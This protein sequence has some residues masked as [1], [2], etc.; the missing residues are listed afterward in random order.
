M[1]AQD[2]RSLQEAYMEVVENQQLDEGY[3][4]LPKKKMVRKINNTATNAS[5]ARK[6][7][8]PKT[9]ASVEKKYYEPIKK[10]RDVK[11]THSSEKA[12]AKAAANKERGEN[13]KRAFGNRLTRSDKQGIRDSY[14][15]YDIIL[16]HLLDEGYAETPEAAEALW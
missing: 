11:D 1:D 14:D 13:K 12:Q 15:Y 10:M 7:N 8:L 5:I 9:V 6:D 3:K 4:D 16:S 2:F